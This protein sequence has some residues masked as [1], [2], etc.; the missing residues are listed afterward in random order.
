MKIPIDSIIIGERFRKEY[1]D[2]PKL[3]ESIKRIGL[4]HPILIDQDNTLVAGGR[5]LRA[6]IYLDREEIEVTLQTNLTELDK[7]IIELEEN[8]QREN[9][10][11]QEVINSRAEIH[12]IMVERYESE[13]KDED[14]FITGQEGKQVNRWTQRQ[15]ADML[16]IAEQTLA[17]DLSH[18]NA[19]QSIPSLS[20]FDT[21]QDSRR[22]FKKVTNY[23]ET[24]QMLA[25]GTLELPTD[26]DSEAMY[27]I[28]DAL[29][30]MSVLGEENPSILFAEVD[31]PYGI[32]LDKL[33]EGK[34]NYEEWKKEEF[35]E[36][37]TTAA[38]LVFKTLA[39]DSW[40]IWWFAWAHYEV[41]KATLNSVGFVL[42]K[43]PLIWN[44]QG[45]KHTSSR[46]DL[47]L[48]RGYEQCFVCRKGTPVL[49][50][51]GRSNVFNYPP[52]DEGERIHP[53]QRPVGLIRDIL[54]TF[55]IPGATVLS[56]FLGSG[57]TIIAAY[58]EEMKCFGW[59]LSELTKVDYLKN[60]AGLKKIG[61]F[62]K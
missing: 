25:D 6:Y 14:G 24:Q 7:R 55:T 29:E 36:K 60:V 43:V 57:N 54:R 49:P 2:I 31:T 38:S 47:Y 23:V 13:N 10:D 4:I 48:A 40:C 51:A 21:Q 9:L 45:H 32:D 22:A 44:K 11:W 12:R 33:R 41:I 42:D 39:K 15:T 19:M 37:T 26:F 58:Q 50:G 35:E 34:I 3:A 62:E 1:K 5:R 46:P 8:V 52:P 16:G 28:G 59:D 61:G 18:F 27:Q 56:P 53:A 30:G 20:D 17:N